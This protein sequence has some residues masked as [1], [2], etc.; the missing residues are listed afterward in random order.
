MPRLAF[1]TLAS[2]AIALGVASVV[3]VNAQATL[4][5][6]LDRAT[7][8]GLSPAAGTQ[9]TVNSQTIG[10]SSPT[11]AGTDGFYYIYNVP[12][13]PYTL[14]VWLPGTAPMVFSLTVPPVQYFDIAPIRVP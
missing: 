4:R 2:A 10:R 9:V 8:Y 6:R 7:P 11:Y 1:R 3:P 14:E 5:G 13:G 12:P